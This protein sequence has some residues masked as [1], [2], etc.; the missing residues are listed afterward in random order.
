MYTGRRLENN[1]I[2]ISYNVTSPFTNKD[3]SSGYTYD[4]TN[5]EQGIIDKTQFFKNPLSLLLQRWHLLKN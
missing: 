5:P 1:M 2:R 4:L 3:I